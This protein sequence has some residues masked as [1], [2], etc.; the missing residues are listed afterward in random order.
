MSQS[1]VTKD[2]SIA[3][4]ITLTLQAT[5]AMLYTTIVNQ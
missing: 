5:V 1:I 3:L 4:N 2:I